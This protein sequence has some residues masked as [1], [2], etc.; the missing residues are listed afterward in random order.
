MKTF[1]FCCTMAAAVFGTL[2]LPTTLAAGTVANPT[3]PATLQ[4]SAKASLDWL[5]T[6]D[7]GNYGGSW[8]QSSA[9]MKLTMPKDE[10]IEM[11]NSMR[12][13]LGSV[14]TRTVA[15]QRTAKDPKGLP[16]GDYVVMFYNTSFSGRPKA[17]ELVTLYFDAG[18]WGVMTY[19]AN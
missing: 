8:D 9:V 3:D 19:Q 10:W 13:P 14:I 16:P 18:E 5:K 11:L 17:N 15:D 4:A 1:A 7:D 6:V 2:L 12:K